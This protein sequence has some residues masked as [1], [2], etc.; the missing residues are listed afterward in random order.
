MMS[1]I[2]SVAYHNIGL[3]DWEPYVPWMFA[4]FLQSFN[5]PVFY[6]QTQNNR[7]HN[8][9]INSSKYFNG[10]VILN[11]FSDVSGMSKWIVATLGS[12]SST[13]GYLDNFMTT[14]ATYLH[15][16]NAGKWSG[17]LREFLRKLPIVFV[18]RYILNTFFFN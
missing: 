14:I 3:I 17:K 11:Y 9:G 1:L 4:K 12:N 15:G 16:S 13:Q 8:L 18:D 2:A 7:Q 5:L 10:D 6:K